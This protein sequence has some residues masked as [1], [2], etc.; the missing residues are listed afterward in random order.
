LGL[1]GSNRTAGLALMVVGA[2]SFIVA[3]VLL[4]YLL[5]SDELE[6]SW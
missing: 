1:F 4:N 5:Q 6:L 3:F 2:T